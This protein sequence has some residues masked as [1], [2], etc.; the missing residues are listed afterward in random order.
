MKGCWNALGWRYVVKA[1]D[2][3]VQSLE[4]D[5]IEHVFGVPGEENAD[6]MIIAS[7]IAGF[8]HSGDDL[9]QFP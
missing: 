7:G 5:G 2:L 1:S 4:A 8:L 9:P 3:F 6:F